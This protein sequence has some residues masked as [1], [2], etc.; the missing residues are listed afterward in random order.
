MTRTQFQE[1]F[2]DAVL[3]DADDENAAD[4]KIGVIEAVQPGPRGYEYVAVREAADNGG[5]DDEQQL[6]QQL[7][8]VAAETER[9]S[10][11]LNYRFS[12]SRAYQELVY[13]RAEALRLSRIL[14]MQPLTDYMMT[15]FAP[16]ME[17]RDNLTLRIE[18]LS[19]RVARASDMLRTGDMVFANTDTEGAPAGGIFIIN[20]NASGTVDADDMTQI[21]GTDTD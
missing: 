4:E 20:A 6:L 17:T 14:G 13:Q 11:S 8:R 12:A 2:P 15:R 18:T 1:R 16:A 7:S 19:R 3:L 5:T 10:A 21:G 9:I